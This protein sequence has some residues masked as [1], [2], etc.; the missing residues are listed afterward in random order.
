MP[1]GLRYV[2]PAADRYASR[3]GRKPSTMSA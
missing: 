1:G 2:E 3:N